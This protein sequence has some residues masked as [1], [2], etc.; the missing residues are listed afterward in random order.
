MAALVAAIASGCFHCGEALPAQPVL[1]TV[2]DAARAFCCAGCAEAARWIREAGLGQYYQ[3]R[4]AGAPRID[5]EALDYREWMQAEVLAEHSWAV[6]GGLE[7]IVLSSGLRCAA[8]AWLIDRALGGQ[9]G[10]LDVAANAV[11]GRI[12]L[13]WDPHKVELCT[14]LQRLAALGFAPAL[15]AGGAQERER[16]REARRD[17]W[18]LGLAG[19]GAMQAMMFAEAL[20]LDTAGQMPLATRDFLR[21]ITVLVS[22]PVVFVAGWPFLQGL[23]RGLRER[24]ANMDVLVGAS[25]LVAWAASLVETLRGGAQVWFDAAVMFVFLLLTAR[26]LEQWARRR[27][28]ARADAL[29]RARPAFARREREDGAVERI[30]AACIRAGDILHVDAGEALP[31]DGEL[32]DADAALDEALLSGEALPVLRRRGDSVAAGS[33]CR[34]APLRLRVLRSGAATQLAQLAQLAAQAQ[35]QRPRLLRLADRAARH[36]ITALLVAAPLVFAAWLYWQPQRAVEVLLAVL[37]ISCPCALSLA[38]PA[39][40]ATA[41][42]ALARRG[43]L[44]LRADALETLAGVDVLLLDK[45]GTLT[46][47]SLALQDL[48]TFGGFDPATARDIAA[49]LQCDASHPLAAAFL[50]AA[51]AQCAAAQRRVIAGQGVQGRVDGRDYRLGRADFA[52]T[53]ADDGAVWLGDGVQAFARFSIRQQLRDDAADAVAAL[54]RLGVALEISSGDSASATGAVAQSL[55]I[56]AWRARQTAQDKLARARALQRQGYRVAMLGDGINDAAVLAG[57]S[58][59]FAFAAGA[60]LTHRAADF[61]LT[62][63]ALAR[64]AES[65]ALARRTRRIV[66][67]NLAWAAAYNLLALPF[68]A[69]GWI[70]PWLAALGMAASSLLVVLNALRLA[71][72]GA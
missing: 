23:A 58:V 45:T 9:A 37:V 32:L 67:Q 11:T 25:I 21:W 57:A 8:C 5:G 4:Q 46:L 63:S 19:L 38:L 68:A 16:R 52:A 30:A 40:L 31:A 7:I 61:L 60:A 15:A 34:A 24:S 17:L 42:D 54:R 56:A 18:R 69:L 51:P 62:G 64:I 53:G 35:L 3:L 70:A 33:I 71:R 36:F 44:V 20:Y 43:V 2:D 55:G 50:A 29:A 6:P 41:G 66:R 48:Q 13:R 26:Q 59:S 72:S 22:T 1:R 28:C 65:I 39:A 47:P 10:V 27:A 49:A 12:R 14:L